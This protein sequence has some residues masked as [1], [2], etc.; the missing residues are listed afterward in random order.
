V[1]GALVFDRSAWRIL[2]AGLQRAT[3][4]EAV[5]QLKGHATDLR[6][7]AIE[8]ARAVLTSD[9]R[10]GEIALQADVRIRVERD[11]FVISII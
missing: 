5:C 6:Y 10:L 7:S 9:A 11:T 8:E 3:L 4:R 1:H 2:P